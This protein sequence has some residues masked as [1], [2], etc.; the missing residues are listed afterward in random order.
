MQARPSSQMINATRNFERPDVPSVQ[1]PLGLDASSQTAPKARML[2]TKL[3]M[4]CMLQTANL[5][6][7]DPRAFGK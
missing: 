4:P 2:D 5:L 1:P 7:S 6:F 3:R